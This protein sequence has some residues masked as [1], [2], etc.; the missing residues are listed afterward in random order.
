MLHTDKPLLCIH[1]HFYQPPREDPF[2]GAVRREPSAAPYANWNERI[3]AECYAPNVAAGNFE[4]ISFNLGGTLA[5][6]MDSQAHDV[7]S[8]IVEAAAR[9]RERHGETNAIAQAVHHTILPLARGRDKRC[10]IQ[11]GIASFIYRFG[12]RPAGMWLPEMAVDVET[13]AMVAA[14]GLQFV[15]L[16]EEQV[17]GDRI[18][19]AGPYK[20]PLGA[21][22]SIAVFVRER[23][24]SDYL[25]FQ[26]PSA[27]HAKAWMNT[28]MAERRPGSL[29]LIATDGETFG[30]HHQHGV[31]VLQ[32]LTEERD[33]DS[34]RTTT[35]TR[36]LRDH[37][38]VA[39][40]GIRENTAWSCSH[41]LGRW[42]TGCACTRG[43]GHWKGALRRALDNLSR[44]VDEVYSQA[45]RRR[46]VGPWRLRDDYIRVLMG[47][48]TRDQF[49]SHHDLGHLSDEARRQVLSLLESQVYRQRMFTSCAFFF[50]ELERI[51]P[52]Y[53][54]ANAVQAM[55]L[56]Y[57]A[58]GD[59]LTRAFQRDLSVAISSRTGRTGADILDELL[60]QAN[61][62][63]SPIGGDMALTRPR[64]RR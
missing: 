57:Y 56:I 62:G 11:W 17:M 4:R 28:V 31:N 16:S 30:H 29:A 50:D 10:Q 55:A 54:I 58:T 19:G 3:T 51:E 45:I 63:G 21:D 22:R 2:T 34:Y 36:Y 12:Y 25:S 26:M 9:H 40:L 43:C 49:L 18:D 15:I 64:A 42:A 61:F 8:G 38:P 32:A 48:V 53:A 46:D 13:L 33:E 44:D 5:R 1:G 24:L 47:Q 37:P 35:L 7:Y 52:R 60:A 20:I 59:D 6:W 27:A 14:A 41:R 23:G 39:E